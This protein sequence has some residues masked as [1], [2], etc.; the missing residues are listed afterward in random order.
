VAQSVRR[1]GRGSRR[2]RRAELHAPAD[3]PST[4]DRHHL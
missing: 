3:Q 2:C 4:S 1:R